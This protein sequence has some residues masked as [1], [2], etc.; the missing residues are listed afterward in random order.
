[1]SSDLRVAPSQLET[2]DAAEL[3]W[4]VIEP[5]WN[6]VNIY[7]GPEALATDL[8][9]LSPGQRALLALHWCISEV[10]NGGFD[11]FFTNPS[12]LLADNAADGLARIGASESVRILREAIDIFASRPAS[13]ELDDPAFDEAA[14]AEAFDAYRARHAPLEDRF[15]ELIET[16][17]YPLAARYVREHAEEF[18]ND[19][20]A[21]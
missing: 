19:A 3:V 16:E 21:A 9:P 12:G 6:A 17:L 13:P 2:S 5:A 18:T 4:R 1:M 14:D 7:D 15:Y 11:Q 8:A 10:S 20:P